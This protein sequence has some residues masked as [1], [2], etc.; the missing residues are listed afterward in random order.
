MFITTQKPEEKDL[1]GYLELCLTSMVT[2]RQ[3]QSPEALINLLT[4][5]YCFVT[6]NK[7][8]VPKPDTY[9]MAL[10][11]LAGSRDLSSEEILTIKK[12]L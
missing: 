5:T 7:V 4:D 2:A 9:L 12:S 3:K 10:S 8:S 1:R 11:A 6:K